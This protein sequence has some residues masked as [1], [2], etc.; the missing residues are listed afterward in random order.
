LLCQAELRRL[1]L[2]VARLGPQ[3]PA[4]VKLSTRVLRG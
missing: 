1:P 3:S 2:I 4:A